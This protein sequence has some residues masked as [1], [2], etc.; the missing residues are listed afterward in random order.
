MNVLLAENFSTDINPTGWYVSEKLDGVRAIWDGENLLSRNGKIFPAPPWFKDRL[1]K[2]T[3][4]D[5]ELWLGRK[6]F[7]QASSI[8]RSGSKD[9]GWN[10]LTYMVFDIPEISAAPVEMRWKTLTEVVNHSCFPQLK[11]LQQ[12]KCDGFEQLMKLLDVV[13]DIGAEALMLRKPGSR[14]EPKRSSTLLKLK[15]FFDDEA[16]VVGYTELLSAGQVVPGSVGAIEC[17]TTKGV[18]F[19]V[20]TGFTL[21]QRKAS[22]MPPIGSKITYK[23]QEL[24]KTGVPRFP[25]YVGVRDYE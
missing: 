22:A 14:Y 3:K 8:I 15:K 16:T 25:V 5:G 4:L 24:S 18:K 10:K 17:L 11:M 9:K 7:E 20:G 19:K 2:H 23:Y 21:A 13:V 1:P 12:V 6:M